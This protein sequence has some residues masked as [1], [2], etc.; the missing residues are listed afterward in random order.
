MSEEKKPKKEKNP[1]VIPAVMVSLSLL[2]GAG[3]VRDGQEKQI[4]AMKDNGVSLAS[5]ASLI[6]GV[7]EALNK[8]KAV[9]CTSNYKV[10]READK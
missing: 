7:I 4:A 9:T 2:G 10:T 5:L 1:R 8:P 3:I 6:P